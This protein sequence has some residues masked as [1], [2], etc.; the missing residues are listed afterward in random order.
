MEIVTFTGT[1]LDELRTL[2]A[3]HTSPDVHTLRVA[4]DGGLKVKA[5]EDVWTAPYGAV[6]PVP[7]RRPAE[8]VGSFD[9]E[10]APGRGCDR[11]GAVRAI[12]TGAGVRCALCGASA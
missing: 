12:V 11:C 6:A 3:S 2:L 8:V 7:A 9:V 5:N 10:Y 4:V 1:A